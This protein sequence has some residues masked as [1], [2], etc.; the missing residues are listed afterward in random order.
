MFLRISGNHQKE[1]PVDGFLDDVEDS[2]IFFA[3]EEGRIRQY[4]ERGLYLRE[5]FVQGKE[6]DGQ[7]GFVFHE[8][9]FLFQEILCGRSVPQDHDFIERRRID[10]PGCFL[11]L[12]R[13][14][15]QRNG[16]FQAVGQEALDGY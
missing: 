2:G 3:H 8:I 13:H 10:E 7:N 9:L 5:S 4:V 6:V 11:G 16:Q 14:F 15:Q 12:N 1:I